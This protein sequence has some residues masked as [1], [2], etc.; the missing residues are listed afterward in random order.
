MTE[1]FKHSFRAGWGE[2]DYN[3][4]MGNTAYLDLSA[5]TRLMYFEANGFAAR[6]FERERIG[7]VVMRDV[8]EYH[9]EVRLQEEISV[10]FEL[11]GL[12]EDGSRFR[13]CNTFLKADGSVAAVVTTDAGW[14]S[15]QD[16]RLVIPPS[17]LLSAMRG[18]ARTED[19]KE[20]PSSIRSKSD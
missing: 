4:H 3:A 7:P 19:F 9:S 11:A 13:L 8:I 15:L 12:S 2:M 18:L 6:D 14:L 10:T 1:V 16:R 17:L 20:L 5:D